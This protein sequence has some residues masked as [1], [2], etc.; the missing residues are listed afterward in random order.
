MKKMALEYI[1]GTNHMA[2]QIVGMTSV[3]LLLAPTLEVDMANISAC[4]GNF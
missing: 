2:V 1:L 4:S 3:S